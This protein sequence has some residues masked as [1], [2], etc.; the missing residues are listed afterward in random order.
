MAKVSTVVARKNTIEGLIKTKG[1]LRLD[2]SGR[3]YIETEDFG[4]MDIV[5]FID[6][7]GL[8]DVEVELKI[9]AKEEVTD[10]V[11]PLSV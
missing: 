9:Q 1:I 2:D 6:E 7:L 10:D 5:A 11:D 3:I 4:V 8:R